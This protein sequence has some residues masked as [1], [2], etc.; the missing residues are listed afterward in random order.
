MDDSC[1]TIMRSTFSFHHSCLVWSQVT[2]VIEEN[3][4]KYNVF[5]DSA[6]DLGILQRDNPPVITNKSSHVLHTDK[7]PDGQDVWDSRKYVFFTSS[8]KLRDLTN[9]LVV[10]RARAYGMKVS[11]EK[12]KIMID[13]TN[14]MSAL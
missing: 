1:V 2:H 4:A 14:N 3:T 5:F 10:G 7:Q 8:G 12:S 6:G 11:T 9:R 13:S